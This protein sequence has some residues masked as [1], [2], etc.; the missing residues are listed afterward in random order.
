MH[1]HPYKL[2]WLNDDGD[3][4]VTKQVVI[5]FSIGK[6]KDE[7]MCD[8]VPMNACHLLLGRPWQFEKSVV[9]NGFKN[10]YSFVKDGKRIVLAPV[11]PQQI[12]QE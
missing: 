2:Q 3:V 8:I 7:V 4:K 6:Y 9:Y 11:S 1:P 5:S 12:D 10:I